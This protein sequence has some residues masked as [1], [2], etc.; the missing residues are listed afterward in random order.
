MNNVF[1]N[2]ALDDQETEDLGLMFTDKIQSGLTRAALT[3]C[4]DW[5]EQ[6]RVMGKPFPGAWTFKHHPW[7]REMHDSKAELNVGKKAAQMGYTEQVLNW[8]FFNIDILGESVLYVLPTD[9]NASDFSAA[10]FDAALDLSPHLANLFNDVKNTKLKRAGGACL[11]VRGSRSKTN[12]ISVPVS[13][14]AIDELNKMVVANIE[15]LMERLSGQVS[16]QTWM[17]STPTVPEFGIDLYY[18]RS[19]QEHFFFV[20]PACHRHEELIFPENVVIFGDNPMDA[21]TKESYYICKQCKAKLIHETKDEWMNEGIWVPQHKDRD[22]RG[23]YINQLYSRTVS[24]YELV[25]Q[26]HKAQVDP[27]AEQELY[28]SKIGVS[29]VVAGARIQD[30]DISGCE[31]SYANHTTAS[32]L[33]VITMGV[34]IGTWLHFEI[35]EWFED[36]KFET[37]D[38]HLNHT[39]KVVYTGKVK[40]FEELDNIMAQYGIHYAVIDANPERRKSLDFCKRFHGRASACF[41]GRDQKAREITQGVMLPT[42]TVDRTSWLD[43]SLSRFKGQRIRVPMDLSQEYRNHIKSIM[44]VYEKDQDGNPTASFVSIASDHHA[45]ARNYAEIALDMALSAGTVSDITGV[46]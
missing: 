14:I 18:D 19:S 20:C 21:R 24:P 29:H 2:L 32:N 41:Y 25:S 15:L 27:V 35:D 10:R 46:M 30:T 7:L 31:A 1:G 22:S 16:K 43:L 42:I 38:I 39:P 11:Y 13:R 17:L 6:Y 3:K 33:H 9:D 45:H 37:N 23:F 5:S 8:S 40:E 26:Y 4:S 36:K 44:K 12:L 34:D 28:N